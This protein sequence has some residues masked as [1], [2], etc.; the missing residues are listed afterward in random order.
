M[1]SSTIDEEVERKRKAWREQKRARL[2][3]MTPE[4]AA[5]KKARDYA[6]KRARETTEE[7]IEKRRQRDRKWRAMNPDSVA[8]SRQ[9][10]KERRRKIAQEKRARK[11]SDPAYIEA[12]R[13]KQE[14]KDRRLA[15]VR[16]AKA[17][18]QEERKQIALAKALA[19]EKLSPEDRNRR[20][21]EA[22]VKAQ[23]I[24]AAQQRAER[25]AR[26]SKK[27]Q[28]LPPPPSSPAVQKPP[29]PRK[30]MSRFTAL[31]KWYGY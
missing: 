7:G 18:R 9:K 13:L 14:E 12:I 30:R 4:Q 11:L 25:E 26:E 17:R 29:E 1:T 2:K 19:K 23:R 15:E 10:D 28:A 21:R 31:S 24:R 3:S 20:R 6:A 8:A 5:E 27:Q 16:A 22:I